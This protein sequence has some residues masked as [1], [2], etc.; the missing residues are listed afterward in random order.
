MKP[1]M[2]A[3]MALIV[4]IVIAAI[5]YFVYYGKHTTIY[6][7]TTIQNNIQNATLT[8]SQVISALGN[9]WIAVNQSN[10]GVTNTTYPNGTKGQILG[11][12]LATFSNGQ[13]LL[14]DE[15]LQFES[16]KAADSYVNSSF[17]SPSPATTPTVGIQ[18]NAKYIFY[19]NGNLSEI[20]AA[21]GNYAI[22]IFSEN[23][24]FQLSNAKQLLI[25]QL[26]NLKIS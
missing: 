5:I 6:P 24:T 14:T 16:A 15:W 10:Y 2:L 18:G 21:D 19:T 20:D 3:I 9:G 22:I 26:S 23:T 13:T 8:Q 12:G 7:T 4:A 25:D 17:G 1:S 11:Y